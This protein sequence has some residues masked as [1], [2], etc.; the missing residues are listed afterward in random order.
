MEYVLFGA[1]EFAKKAILNIKKEDVFCF[2]DNNRGKENDYLEGK[3]IFS[4]ED[5]MKIVDYQNKKIYITSSTYREIAEQLTLHGFKEGIDFED[6]IN[7][8]SLMQIKDIYGMEQGIEDEFVEIFKKTKKYTMTSWIRM[9]HLFKS[10]EYIAKNKINGDIVE[11]G[12]WKGGSML[13]VAETLELFKDYSRNIY[14]FDTYQG[15]TEPIKGVDV[16]YN[17]DDAYST[18]TLRN[19]E[20]YNTWSYASLEDVQ[21]NMSCSNYPSNKLHFIV[22]DV[23]ETIPKSKIDK[24]SL[25]RLDTDW[26]ESTKIEMEV[27]YPKLLD[28][29]VLIVDD[30]GDWLGSQKAVDEYF[31]DVL[32]NSPFL[33]RIDRGARMLIK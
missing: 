16:G 25:L 12:V 31:S 4:F 32:S 3:R 14:L 10:I 5:F 29:G 11:C 8:L 17:G 30:Y 26:Y 15:M 27:F 7:L 19:K 22:G 33:Y 23:L 6:G 24:I 28:K 20:T 1:G 2:I 13:L 21:K 18:W 9:Y